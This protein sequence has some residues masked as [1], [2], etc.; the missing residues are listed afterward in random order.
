M[1]KFILLLSVSAI[2]IMASCSSIKEETNKEQEF[3]VVTPL[4]KDTVYTREYVA[5]IKAFQNVEIRA[6]VSGFIE[7]TLADEGETVRKGQ[8]LF[9]FNNK[10][11]QHDL[12][13]AKAAVKSALAELNSAEI[14]LQGSKKLLDR[15]II[16]KPEYDLAIVKVESLNAKLEEAQSDEARANLNLSFTQI[17][18]PFDGVI[19]R[20]PN[21]A[22][23]LVEEG[24]L[25]TTISNNREMFAYFNVSEVDYL[26][27]VTSKEVGSLEDVFLVLANGIP[28][29]YKGIIETTESEFDKSTGTIAFRA[30]FP[31]P[32]FIL[33]HGAT[34]KIQVNTALKNAI[35][36]PQKSTFDQQEHLCV[37]VVNSN[38]IVQVRKITPSVRLPRLFVIG[39]G[40]SPQ[41]KII[42]E[43]IQRIKD[44][45]KIIPEAVSFSQ[46]FN[47]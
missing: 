5:E 15:N 26:E 19:N 3:K 10:Q 43:G 41:E 7:T 8:V 39:S 44:G 4:V 14:E 20:I 36:I 31:N 47:Q 27:Y 2:L 21:K 30:K 42:Y 46:V 17:E 13:K 28:Y 24:T 25:L 40:L 32:E 33:K 12:Q 45:D 34:G 11:F 23:S 1:K 18:A 35:L 37:F 29:P 9:T 6:R 16:S 38:N 22:G